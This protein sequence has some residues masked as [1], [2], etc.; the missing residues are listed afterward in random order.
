MKQTLPIWR[1]CLMLTAFILMSVIGFSQASISTCCSTT[2]CEGDSVI[3]TSS[4]GY[5]YLWSNGATTPSIVVYDSGDYTVTVTD[6]D[7]NTSTSPAVTVTVNPLPAGSISPAGPITLCKGETTELTASGGVSYVWSNGATTSSITV[8]KTGSYYVEIT[9]EFGCSVT[10]GP[11]EVTVNPKPLAYITAGDCNF[12]EGGSVTL[13]SS[14]GS[15]YLWNT[16]ETTQSI[17]VTTSGS[18]EV[19]VTNAYGCYKTSN[20]VTVTVYENPEPVI[21][22]DGP[23]EF[24]DGGSV[25]LT[26]SAAASYLWSTGETTQ[27]ITVD[28]TGCYTVTVTSEDGC[29]GSDTICVTE[30]PNPVCSIEGILEICT[31]ECTTLTAPEG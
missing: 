21:S 12:C 25:T 2:I 1:M 15:S 18:Y 20:S 7:G 5:G 13:T 10:L 9:N 24:C 22:A 30:Y 23:T 31:G 19:T 16:G 28:G 3:L 11:V 17:E 27:S 29:E 14:P 4:P 8:D 26:S 6:A